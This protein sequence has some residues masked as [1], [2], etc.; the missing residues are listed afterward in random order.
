MKT[1]LLVDDDPAVIDLLEAR[2][3]TRFTV[4]STPDPKRALA[5]AR[6]RKPDLIL[7]DVDMPGM[8]GAELGAALRAAGVGQVPVVFLTGLVSPDEVRSLPAQSGLG[9]HRIIAKRAPFSELL[10]CI[11]SLIGK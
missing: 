11:E 5:L 8:N 3:R 1:I 7:S 10:A 6:E 2:L 9:S 4:V